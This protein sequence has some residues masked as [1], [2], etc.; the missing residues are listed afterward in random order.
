MIFS[1]HCSFELI[2]QSSR[3][4]PQCSRLEGISEQYVRLEEVVEQM[5][6]SQQGQS[7]PTDEQH[8]TRSSS[9]DDE[10]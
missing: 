2:R 9:T 8:P 3:E 6:M 4:W 10:I 7:T 1:S 5:R